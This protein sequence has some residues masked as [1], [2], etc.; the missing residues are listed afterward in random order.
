M[1]INVK[2]RFNEGDTVYFLDGKLQ[3]CVVIEIRAWSK[4]GYISNDTISF[5][6]DIKR[7]NDGDVYHMRDEKEIYSSTDEF[8]A[9]IM[10]D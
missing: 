9:S 2:S 5:S 1:E 10:E 3:K 8:I 7:N 6:Y 4:S